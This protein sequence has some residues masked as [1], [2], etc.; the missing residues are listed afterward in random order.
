MTGI[1]RAILLSIL[2]CGLAAPAAQ[3]K[4][5]THD[6]E[7]LGILPT[8]KQLALS[9]ELID[10][11]GWRIVIGEKP[12][13]DWPDVCHEYVRLGVAGEEINDRLRRLGADPLPVGGAPAGEGKT[14]LV[15][16]DPDSPALGGREQGYRIEATPDGA[17]LV[18]A[19]P[20]G[21]LYAAVTLRYMIVKS[22]GRVGLL[23][24]RVLDWPDFAYRRC[25]QLKH[26]W[27]QDCPDLTEDADKWD[28][29]AEG[30]L[31]AQQEQ[32]DHVFRLKI[33]GAQLKR[34]RR[35]AF[36]QDSP[37]LWS[38][39]ARSLKKVVDYC[40]DRGILCGDVMHSD[41]SDTVT[42]QEA[43]NCFEAGSGRLFSWSLE[44]VHRRRAE[45]MA[46]RAAEVGLDY[47]AL[48]A[49][50]TGGY[51]D[52]ER[53]SQRAVADRKMYADDE[54]WKASRDQFLLYY[55]AFTAARPSIKFEAVTYPYFPQFVDPEFWRKWRELDMPYPCAGWNLG[56][57]MKTQ[58]DAD[59]ICR[60]LIE[61]NRK[62]AEA[63]PDGIIMGW[64]EVDR[65]CL[66]RMMEIYENHP[67]N[68]WFYPAQ[69]AGWSA[70][71]QPQIR[72]AAT[73][74]FPGRRDIIY[75]EPVSHMAVPATAEYVWNASAVPDGSREFDTWKITYETEGRGVSDYQRESVLP[76][77]C[78]ML[79]GSQWRPFAEALSAGLSDR[80]VQDPE[81]TGRPGREGFDDV[82]KYVH[83]QAEAFAAMRPRFEAVL[84]E[85]DAGEAT[86]ACGRDLREAWSYPLL[87]GYCAYYIV[88]SH[89][90]E[91]QDAYVTARRAM[92]VGQRDQAEAI[93]REALASLG[94]RGEQV[95]SL[96][97][98]TE[99]G[100]SILHLPS[101]FDVDQWRNRLQS[102]L[103]EST[104]LG[105]GD[106]RRGG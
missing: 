20:L 43:E 89:V 61:Y 35:R 39:R 62:L 79:F 72:F 17:R 32:I 9:G 99:G 60:R 57:G 97:A 12:D 63:L 83:D 22:N 84:A 88:G 90:A 59:R 74:L 21:A 51:A 98:R 76:R 85:A 82:Y 64:R 69:S 80:Y 71:F 24:G 102:V 46:R 47:I 70:P 67:V 36:E 105:L 3:A 8:P 92:A 31:A 14:I 56:R 49:V 23:G 40:H 26:W 104:Y 37:K 78:K 73:F 48:H 75:V 66:Q 11:T 34:F 27:G 44:D 16:V 91:L 45:K 94:E 52:P 103:E 65:A 2:A 96:L 19:D 41:I 1:L 18:G 42:S 68:L 87:V 5:N 95:E 53:W 106:T 7:R 54:R 86:A 101:G 6:A 29:V 38:C 28:E 81:N 100:P 55:R 50:D 33:N 25:I 10:L 13:R 93:V 77:T 30:F 15:Q 58:E 4:L